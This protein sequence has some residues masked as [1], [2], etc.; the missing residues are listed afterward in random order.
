M[1]NRD[2]FVARPARGLLMPM[3]VAVVGGGLTGLVA[4]RALRARDI[5]V[6]LIDR[7][8]L[9]GGRLRP[10]TVDI[11]AAGRATLD[12]VPL[13]LGPTGYPTDDPRAPVGLPALALRAANGAHGFTGPVRR[14]PVVHLSTE[15]NQPLVSQFT[16]PGG[17]RALLDQ[18]VPRWGDDHLKHLPWTEATAIER[19]GTGW[20]VRTRESAAAGGDRRAT[21]SV[22]ADAVLLTQPVPAALD[23]LSAGSTPCHEAVTDEARRVRYSRTLVLTAVYRGRSLLPAGPLAVSDSPVALIFDNGATGASAVGPAL[24]AVASETWAAEHWHES[25]E[26]L[27]RQLLALVS[28]WADG[29]LVWHAVR[30]HE[31]YRA[32]ERPR[33]PFAV[34]SDSPSLVLAGDGFAGY[35]R[36]PF[37]AA[38]T[39]ALHATDHIG[40]ELRRVARA[41]NRA[42]PRTPTKPVLEVAV[43]SE[44]EARAAVENGADRLL[45][46]AA[47]EVGGLTPT[48]DTVLSVRRVARRAGKRL[49]RSIPVTVLLRPRL[50]ECDYTWDEFEQMTR[51]AKRFLKARADGIAFGALSDRGGETRVDADACRPLVA[52]AHR[53][54]KEAVFHRAFD[55]LKDRRTG[56]HDLIALGFDRVV[57]AGRWTLAL[58]DTAELAADVAYAG[59]DI[60]VVVTG[61]VTAATAGAVVRE[62]HCRHLLGGFREP[63]ASN[64]RRT[65]DRLGRSLARAFL[66]D[67]VGALV[68]GLGQ[69]SED[70]HADSAFDTESDEDTPVVDALVAG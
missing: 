54:G 42:V 62:T 2:T 23:L 28:P 40:R 37:D 39:S 50:G 25:D 4:A 55:G 7:G 48:L 44:C 16:V 52:L 13:F 63:R 47:P 51:D 59:W 17:A 43:S 34:A 38:Y 10:T 56:L 14:T 18:L 33:M 26:E 20:R 8:G 64:N 6:T 22:L 12:P 60:E 41:T 1:V 27:A 15:G 58:D 46:L 31:H 53:F 9:L 5:A 35:V 45:V 61:G 11:P 36:N 32:G 30:R 69:P 67:Q 3:H 70:P 65:P 24:T 19:D 21:A 29:E 49:G 68:A 57:T 66:A